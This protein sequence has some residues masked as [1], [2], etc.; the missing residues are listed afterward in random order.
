MECVVLCNP[1]GQE[2]IRC[3]RLFRVLADR[4]SRSGFHVMRFDYYG[5]GDSDGE[6][7]EG[8][9]DIWIDDV[10]RANEEIVRRS[11]CARCSWFGLRLGASLAALAS[12]KIAGTPKRLLLWDPV[13]DGPGYLAELANAH[14]ASAAAAYGSRWVVESRLRN[15]T[16]SETMAEALGFPL[17][18][19]LKRQLHAIS[20][21]AFSVS[22][23]THVTLFGGHESRVLGD[24]RRHLTAEN[25][26]ADFRPIET[27]IDWTSNAA[28]NSS[29]V[30]ME[31]L[32]SIANLLLE[33]R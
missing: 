31:A 28:M 16:F 8:D 29:I 25:I 3:H 24:L 23:A 33:D 11:G 1:F 2:A 17:T 30:P 20:P 5:T 6:D 27:E 15:M 19:A 10:L 14:I 9:I 32:Q 13:I 12:A 21:T 26:G 7:H 4:L 22:K 18:L